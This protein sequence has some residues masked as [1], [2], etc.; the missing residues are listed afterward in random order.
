[1]SLGAGFPFGEGRPKASSKKDE[2][3]ENLSIL[4]ILIGTR[5]LVCTLNM[6]NKGQWE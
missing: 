1:M 3:R 4:P 6:N 5:P 2:D